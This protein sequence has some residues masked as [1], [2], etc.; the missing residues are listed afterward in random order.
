MNYVAA[1]GANVNPFVARA[2]EIA[3]EHPD[4][5]VHDLV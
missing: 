5:N 1:F 3:V 4:I 2:I